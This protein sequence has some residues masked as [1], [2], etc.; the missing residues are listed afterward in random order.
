MRYVYATTGRETNKNP[1]NSPINIFKSPS[2]SGVYSYPS[3]K[4]QLAISNG[5]ATN[6]NGEATAKAIKTKI[7]STIVIM[8]ATA[9]TTTKAKPITNNKGMARTS[10]ISVTRIIT[11]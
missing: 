11:M 6:K 3:E 10:K 1:M 7:A 4:T 9:M 2:L 8:I 5:E